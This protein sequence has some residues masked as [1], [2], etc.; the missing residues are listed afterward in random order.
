[1]KQTL[2][3]AS[4]HPFWLK[5][6]GL[7]AA[8]LLALTACAEDNGDDNGNGDETEGTED[9]TEDETS[10]PT[11]DDD[12]EPTDDV[13]DD[14][15]D[16]T[17][18]EEAPALSEIEDRVTEV[19]TEAESVTINAEGTPD[20]DADLDEDLE[21]NNGDDNA[22]TDPDED[23]EENNGDDNADTD[24]DEDLEENNGDTDPDDVDDV[25]E[26]E[27]ELLEQAEDADQISVTLRGVP[28]GSLAEVEMTVEDIELTAMTVD[29]QIYLSGE[30]MATSVEQEL[31][32][33]EQQDIDIEGFESEMSGVWVDV[34]THED[35]GDLDDIL[36][37][38]STEESWTETY[39][40]EGEAEERDGEEVWVYSSEDGEELAIL[41]DEDEPYIYSIT[42][43]TNEDD[44]YEMIF[45]DWDDTEVPEEPDEDDI[46]DLEEFQDIWAEYLQ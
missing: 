3:P 36:D 4:T 40:D 17:S 37:Q 8:G 24:P 41:A 14:S 12:S 33:D 26:A 25:D 30:S 34:G 21:E 38:L 5:A 28:D 27:D 9:V 18:S 46:I 45:T 43:E 15:E 6:S 19:V 20:D 16:G 35:M 31:S 22:D 32:E 39:S 42:G 2:S 29:R 1:M 44:S 23:L 7:A 10:E 11:E 13:D